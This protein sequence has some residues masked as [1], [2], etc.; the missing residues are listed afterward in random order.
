MEV[1]T[2]RDIQPGE[3]IFLDYGDEWEQSWQEHLSNWKPEKK[4]VEYISA[5]QMNQKFEDLRTE[6]EQLT[7]PYPPNLVTVFN[8]K[9][10]DRSW[11]G[12]LQQGLNLTTFFKKDLTWIVK[13]EILSYRKVKGRRN[14]KGHIL[15]TA[16]IS[17]LND[18]G[19]DETVLIEDVPRE[20][21]SFEDRPYTSD[22]FLDNAFRHDIR[23]PDDMFPDAWK[24]VEN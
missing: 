2:L 9:F 14:V 8:Q 13:C 19:A 7:D 6:F 17:I 5:Y 16:A 12:A 3:E 23:I 11:E 10:E 22:L 21:F 18:E 1:I 4:A 24:N 20:A 15:Y